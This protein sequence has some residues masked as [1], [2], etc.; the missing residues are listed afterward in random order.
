MAWPL[1]EPMMTWFTEA[2]RLRWDTDH[3]EAESFM[4][5]LT[6]NRCWIILLTIT[7]DYDWDFDGHEDEMYAR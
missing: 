7:L 5:E 4:Q 2:D 6:C 3:V 1:S